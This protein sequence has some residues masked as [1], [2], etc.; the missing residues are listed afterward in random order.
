M[1]MALVI[2]LVSDTSVGLGIASFHTIGRGLCLPPP[3]FSEFRVRLN[4]GPKRIDIRDDRYE[5][6]DSFKS[7]GQVVRRVRDFG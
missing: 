3:I 1:S 7:I 6:T 4:Q 2:W 5:V